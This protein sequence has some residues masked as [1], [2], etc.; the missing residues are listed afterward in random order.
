VSRLAAFV[1]GLA[2]KLPRLPESREQAMV[3]NSQACIQ[4]IASRRTEPL[5]DATGP[6]CSQGGAY[7]RGISCPVLTV[8][9]R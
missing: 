1:N 4:A 9:M 8:P 7:C 5:P 3:R 6:L 2:A